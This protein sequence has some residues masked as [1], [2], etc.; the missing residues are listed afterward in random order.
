MTEIILN[1]TAVKIATKL[2]KLSEGCYLKAYCD[3]ASD[4]AQAIQAHN[5]W[6]AYL[7]GKWA[8]PKEWEY[9]KATP[10]TCGFGETQGVTKN[11]VYTQQ[12]A[13]TK[14]D[15]RVREFMTAA[16]KATPALATFSP[17]RQ[18][19]ITSLVYNIGITNYIKY[20]ISKRVQA[21]DHI[22][23]FNKFNQYIIANG[24]PNDGLRNR[25]KREADLYASVKG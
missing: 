25:R 6:N 15:K 11:T 9:L 4:L 20:D 23:V 24:K 22:A 14:L 12:E 13:D 1:E 7:Q 5:Q 17:E 2:V 21:K 18:A 19:A 8:V 10:Y 3:P 16:I